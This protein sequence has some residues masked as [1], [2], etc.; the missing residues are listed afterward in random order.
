MRYSEIFLPTLKESPSEAEIASHRLMLRAGMIRKLTSGIYSYLP[1]GL[2]A[3]RKI[4]NIVR[5][6]MNRIGA[7]ELLLPLVQ[8]A[9]LWQ[10]TGRWER[11]GKE[12]LRFKDRHNRNFCLGP[13][14]EEVITDL[15][16]HEV[17][18]YR[19]LPLNLYQ[20]QIKFRDE[21]RPRFGI[22]RGREFIMKDGYSFDVDDASAEKTYWQMYETYNR[23]FSRCGL[24]FRAVEAETGAIG[25]S[26]SHEYMVLADV[27]EDAIVFC[28]K[29]KFAANVEKAE[30][31]INDTLSSETPKPKEEVFTPGK[32]TVEEVTSFLGVP[33]KKLVKT[34][35]YLA[36]NKP[37]AVLVRGDHEVNEIKL[38]HLIG[39]N[40]LTLAPP[41]IIKELT[42]AEVG[43]AGPIG[44]NIPILADQSIK[45][46]VNFVTGANKTDYHFI[47]VNLDDFPITQFAD[48]RFITPSDKCPRCGGE[49]EFKRGIE[50]GHIFKLGTKY[51]EALRA[52]YLDAK[53]KER[54]IVMGCYGI[55]IGRTLAA[56]I[57][58]NHDKDGI[59][60]PLPLA[61]F[62]IYLLPVDVKKTEIREIAEELYKRLSVFWEV[63]Y[64]DREERA[65]V[66]FKDADLI[67][68]PLRITIGQAL[69]KG[70]VEI[71][72][73]K[74][75]ETIFTS[76]SEIEAKIEEL[77]KSL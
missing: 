68:I 55:G 32:H 75:K 34:I 18:S 39:C 3:I 5:E 1:F 13:T 45:G 72:I 67:G 51:S 27:G 59:I 64:D 73:R 57:E 12:L 24:V 42:G 43:F 16:R 26:F 74:T 21:I 52:T 71:R 40:E 22:I 20:I 48:L 50:V 62:Q 23:I 4:E 53:G 36:D 10:E 17:R 69:K 35:I 29:C 8:P 33:P 37:I 60:F 65:G 15:V 11:Y 28:K 38:S 9:E 2:R 66:K 44:L 7:Q 31:V 54:Y 58:Q 19:D 56:A 77:I 61:P 14:H 41:E 6:E 70:K 30:V 49:L 47:N 46:M 76:L 25:G 63:I